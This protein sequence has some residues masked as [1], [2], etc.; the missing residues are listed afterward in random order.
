M[1]LYKLSSYSCSKL[2]LIFLIAESFK[3]YRTA[4]RYAKTQERSQGP[5]RWIFAMFDRLRIV[6]GW[7]FPVKGCRAGPRGSPSQLRAVPFW[8]GAVTTR[9]APNKLFWI[10][11]PRGGGCRCRS[12][13]LIQT[14]PAP[15]AIPGAGRSGWSAAAAGSPGAG[16]ILAGSRAEQLQPPQRSELVLHRASA[17]C[18]IGMLQKTAKTQTQLFSWARLAA[19]ENFLT[20]KHWALIKVP[21]IARSRLPQPPSPNASPSGH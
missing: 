13:G 14:S 21:S 12:R 16:I 3:C 4:S 11:S 17:I 10:I 1:F 15:G 18:S 6:L 19:R 5:R 20:V 8:H 7:I 2:A 9:G